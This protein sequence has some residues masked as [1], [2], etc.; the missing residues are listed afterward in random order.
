M[1]TTIL[2]KL[3]LKGL[4]EETT[5]KPVLVMN[6]VTKRVSWQNSPVPR[7]A[8]LEAQVDT[9]NN[10]KFIPNPDYSF[11]NDTRVITMRAGWIGT[12]N[13]V[14]YTNL[15]NV[16]LPEIPLTTTNFTR[17]DLIVFTTAGTFTKIQGQEKLS[18]PV[19]PAQPVNTLEATFIVV[20]STTIEIQ[21]IPEPTLLA[22]TNIVQEVTLVD[23]GIV[24]DYYTK[25][26]IETAVT[27]YRN[28]LPNVV[29][30]KKAIYEILVVT[31]ISNW[32]LFIGGVSSTISSAALLAFKLNISIGRVTNFV[33]D[34]SN[35]KCKIIGSYWSGDWNDDNNLTYFDDKN[36]LVTSVG[37]IRNNPNLYYWNTPNCLNFTNGYFGRECPLLQNAIFPNANILRIDA[38]YESKCNRF[39]I[40]RVIDLGGSV[41]DTNAFY[42]ISFSNPGTYIIYAHPNLA[43]NNAGNPDGDLQEAIS[44]G[45]TVRY[46]TNF[47]APNPVTT[48]AAGTIAA[49]T[50]QLNFT[51][52]TG[53]TNA[54]D[55]Y[56]CWANGVQKN[57]IT[58]SGQNITGLTTETSYNIKLIAVDIFYN[59]SVVSNAIIVST[60]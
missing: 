54:I 52:P 24:T 6:P 22:T 59:K 5:D 33:V 1:P 55:Y 37:Y 30:G 28:T 19:K 32:N 12:I 45:A 35:I 47:V 4:P 17:I 21:P 50:V 34:G 27:T 7:I 49:T 18:S 3:I 44:Y 10:F 2:D 43:T 48:L 60:T 25:N 11:N 29:D 31:V 57:N 23:L 58:A 51:A 13:G 8:A 38:F 41:G 16:V 42:Y 46:V 26:E 15:A 40:P 39:Y 36:G 53:S 14:D 9:E 20:N 56:E